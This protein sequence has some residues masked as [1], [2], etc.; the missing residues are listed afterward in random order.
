MTTVTPQNPT[1]A[2]EAATLDAQ[3]QLAHLRHEFHWP[4]YTTAGGQKAT[5]TYLVGNSLGLQPKVTAQYIEEAMQSWADLAVEGHFS[6]QHPYMYYHRLVAPGLAELVG[7]SEEE[8]V[9]MNGLTTNLHLMLA[10]FYQPKGSR[11][12]ILMEAG[13]FPSDQYAVETM[14]RWHG[15]DPEQH[16][17]EV[18][19]RDGQRHLEHE[20]ITSAIT[21]HGQ[22]IALVMLSGVQYATGQIFDMKSI[23]AAGHAVGAY[24]GWDLAHAVGN[25]KLELHNWNADFACWCTY[26]YL[27]SGPGGISGVFVHERHAHDK[28]LPRLAGWW[29]HNEQDRFLMKKGFDPMPGAQG[30]QH[31]N[32]PILLLASLRGSLHMVA[33]AGWQNLLNK[34]S[35][36][37]TFMLKCLQR[38]GLEKVSLLT[39]MPG[40]CQ[41]SLVVPGGKAVFYA[42]KEQ[43]ILGDWR[44][45]DIIRLSPTPM[46]NSFSDIEKATRVLAE[47]LA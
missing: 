11:T 41:Y 33:A 1:L 26:K 29:G 40:G 10:S 5:Y 6:G 7:A 39:P 37:R 34:Q 16:I 38:P 18:K 19:P 47:V 35:A 21:T 27:N 12:K 32:A 17:I 43:G 24:V 30:W 23:T 36:M 15:L 44:E 2:E 8:V 46:Y 9:A 13:A 45:P 28:D 25:V 3:D 42:L 31:S 14:V 22:E 4:S 20:D